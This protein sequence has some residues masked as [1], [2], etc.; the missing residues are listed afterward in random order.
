MLLI[1][2][3]SPKIQRLVTPLRLQRRRHLRS[4]KRRRLERQKEQKTEYECVLF[5]LRFPIT[6]S[7][8]SFRTL[9]SK[10]IAEKKEK[11]AHLKAVHKKY[12]DLQ[13]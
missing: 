8:V 10:R 13:H 3:S 7:S 2:L 6:C 1:N 5:F 4:L 9:L 12:V 11:V